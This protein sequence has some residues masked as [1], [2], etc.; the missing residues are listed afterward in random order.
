M[1]QL[2]NYRRT[3]HSICNQLIEIEGDLAV[4]NPLSMLIM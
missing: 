3:Q 4:P 2:A 1:V